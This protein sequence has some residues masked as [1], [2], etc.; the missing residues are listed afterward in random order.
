MESLLA[1]FFLNS[2]YL[3]PI[4]GWI[5][6]LSLVNL[7]KKLSKGQKDISKEQIFLTI[8]F[9]IIIWSISGVTALSLS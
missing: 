5:F 9:I 8:S 7:L 2:I 3:M 6:C 1:F 4:Y